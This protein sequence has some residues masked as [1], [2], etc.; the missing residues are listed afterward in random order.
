VPVTFGS[1]TVFY[2][3]NVTVPS[4]YTAVGGYHT[5]P[6]PNQFGEGFSVP[7]MNWAAAHNMTSYVGMSYSGNIRSYTPGVTKYNGYGVTGDLIG[8][9][10]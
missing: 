9:V 10:P 8:N 1:S 7:D 3:D 2:A 6:D 5:H 4:G